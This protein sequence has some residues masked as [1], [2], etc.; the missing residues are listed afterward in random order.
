MDPAAAALAAKLVGAK[1][2][3]PL[4]FGTFPVLLGEPDE[5]AKELEGTGITVLP[6]EI[7]APF[8]LP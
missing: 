6:A 1:R 8:T 2:V 5:L 3:F 4:H 7:G